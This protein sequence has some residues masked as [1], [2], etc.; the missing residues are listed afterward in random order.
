MPFRIAPANPIPIGDL[1]ADQLDRLHS[2]RA[3]RLALALAQ[4]ESLDRSRADTARY[5]DAMT[6][7]QQARLN[8]DR[9]QA[10]NARWSTFS[11]EDGGLVTLD[12]RDPRGTITTLREPAAPRLQVINTGDRLISIDPRTG[13][14]VGQPYDIAPK[15]DPY[16]RTPDQLAA[17]QELAALQR[18]VQLLKER[19]NGIAPTKSPEYAAAVSRLLSLTNKRYGYQPGPAEVSSQYDARFTRDITP[20]SGSLWWKKDAT[21]NYLDTVTGTIVPADLHTRG[22]VAA[23]QSRNPYVDLATLDLR[24]PLPAAAAAST[25]EPSAASAPAAP[26]PAIWTGGVPGPTSSA[27]AT[28][29]SAN[30]L[31]NASSP[32]PTSAAPTPPNTAILELQAAARAGHPKAA[33]YLASKNLSW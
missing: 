19:N 14:P 15:P 13:Q 29:I 3:T 33:A 21:T 22:R 27:P 2:D 26:S 23:L 28:V 12:P 8:H 10:D 31:A 6:R 1:V 32:Q 16:N 4:Q 25:R 11:V 24:T 9:A 18:T 20:E 17:D 30:S 7:L 5:Q